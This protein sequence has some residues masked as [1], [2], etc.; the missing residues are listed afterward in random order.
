MEYDWPGNIRELENT[1]ERA[2]VLSRGEIIELKDLVYHGISAGSSL[3]LPGGGKYKA[4]KDIEKEYIKI[5]L[6]AQHGNK[7][8]TAKILGIDRKTLMAKIKK[9]KIQ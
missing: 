7:S 1:I 5:I 4:L 8:Q 3:L 6:H 9:Y 2:A